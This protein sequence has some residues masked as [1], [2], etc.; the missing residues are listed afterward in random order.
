MTDRPLVIITTRLPPAACG[1]GTYSWLLRQRWPNKSRPVEF[2]VQENAAGAQMTESG[3]R[4]TA[5]DGSGARLFEALERIGPADV[6]L[7][8]AARGYHR[9]GCPVWMP[10]AL[11]RWKMRNPRGRFFLFAH[12]LPAPFPIHSHHFWFAKVNEWIMRRLARLADVL[13]TNSENHVRQLRRLSGRDDVELLLVPSNIE[14][15]YESTPA[16]ARREFL[17]WGLPFGRLQTLQLFDEHIRRWQADGVLTKLH[18]SGPQEGDFVARAEALISQWPRPDVVQRHNALG[19]TASAR[20]LQSTGFAL[21][22]V[23]VET[24]SKSGVFMACAA[25]RC[26]VVVKTKAETVPLCYTI[27]PEEVASITD[28]EV[29]NRTAALEGWYRTNADWPVIAARMA[30]IAEGAAHAR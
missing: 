17:I 28:A 2:L 7:H 16:R 10:R 30:A 9:V 27:T 1:V 23:S 6:L 18:V 24:W 14:P 25:T 4:I 3:D 22:N 21:T 15:L 11:A 8:Y 20:L 19:P 26:P 29:E 12:E 5:F 13:I